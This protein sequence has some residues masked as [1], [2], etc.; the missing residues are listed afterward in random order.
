MNKRKLFHT[1]VGAATLAGCASTSVQRERAVAAYQQAE[2]QLQ[3]ESP[4]PGFADP[5]AL[6]GPLKHDLHK[7]QLGPGKPVTEF[8]GGKAYYLVLELPRFAKPYHIEVL[9]GIEQIAANA[10][11]QTQTLATVW[12]VLSLLDADFQLVESRMPDYVFDQARY[13]S[14]AGNFG[15]ISICDGK[16]RYLAVHGL[17]PLYRRVSADLSHNY[18]QYGTFTG[19]MTQVQLP[20]GELRI[21]I[22]KKP[23]GEGIFGIGS[24]SP[25]CQSPDR[26]VEQFLKQLPSKE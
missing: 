16:A 20:I 11:A 24:S 13:A 7:Y 5:R 18:S 1:L 21:G 9:P 6:A 15:H 25:P 10:L 12:P 3:A 19:L 23:I 4:H 22:P 2:A 26:T 17:P 14:L 8:A